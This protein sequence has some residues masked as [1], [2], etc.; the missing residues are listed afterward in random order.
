LVRRSRT[1]FTS[2]DDTRKVVIAV[3]R[4]YPHAGTPNYWFA[5]HK[6]YLGRLAEAADSYVAFGCGSEETI[7]FV[8]FKEFSG[9]L[10]SLWTTERENEIYWHVIIS[11]G[12]GKYLLHRKKGFERIDLTKCLL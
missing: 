7:L 10:N 4:V 9:W 2:P 11:K 1:I 12:E 6:S 3:S 5:F 8:P